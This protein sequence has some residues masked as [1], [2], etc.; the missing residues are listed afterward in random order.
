MKKMLVVL[1]MLAMGISLFANGAK[2]NDFDL[3][4]GEKKAILLVSFGTTFPETREKTIGALEKEF[5]ADY[6]DFKVVTAFTSR[7]IMRRIKEN[8]GITYDNPSEALK[9]LKK[10][11]YTH[12]LVQGTH[13]MN[14][15]ESET[16]KTEV[17]SYKG[18]FK[19]LKVSTPLLTSV[20]D[21]KEVVKALKPTYKNLKKDEAVVFI[22]HGT[23]HPGNSAYS[24][25]EHVFHGEGVKN[26]FLG[27][28]EGYPAL[29]DV[30]AGLKK[31]K[32]KKVELY[33]F[34]IVA[35]DHANNDI[36]V[37]MK[38]ELEKNGFTVKAHLVGL[39]ENKE[40]RKIFVEHAEFGLTHEEENMLAKKKEYANGKQPL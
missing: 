35:G 3:K 23:H 37:D 19:V 14:A 18:D 15:I 16:L 1:V 7:I 17:E 4:K 30:I 11:G 26:A 25:L 33:P 32:I 29:D 20:E 10:D 9:K 31:A 28:V 6:P 24:M 36:A 5:K 22:G 40:I 8:E 13:I 2:S 21:Y 12:V 27:T 34:M 38:E 39:G